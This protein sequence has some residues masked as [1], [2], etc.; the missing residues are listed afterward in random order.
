ML[1]I[2]G[3]LGYWWLKPDN[4]PSHKQSGNSTPITTQQDTNAETKPSFPFIDLQS[5][6]DT[7]AARQ[8]GTA[9][10]YIYDLANKKVAA[11][12]EPNRQYFTAS[13]YKIYVAY[14][15]YQKIADGTYSFNDTYLTG[16]NRG[17]CLDAMIRASYSPCGEK[18]WV[19]LGK[20]KL[21]NKLKT[22]G[23]NNTSMVGLNTTAHDAGILLQRLFEKRDLT[24]EHTSLYL[25]SMKNQDA[26]YRRGLP[27]G[28]TKSKVYNKVGWNE[29]IEWHDTAI[30]T[31]PNGR[32]YVICVLTQHVG[33]SNIKQ[34]GQAI[35][36]KLTQ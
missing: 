10:V 27:S 20:E 33:Y 34:L 1:V 9:S 11:Q 29:D 22:Y 12:L 13:I 3:C 7:W 19:E 6:V 35:E 23:I 32:S 15:G 16:Y 14:E 24:Q 18:M 31:L 2:I 17:Q 4:K 5:T 21:T 36:V 25:D 28:F 30:V 26:K 8:S